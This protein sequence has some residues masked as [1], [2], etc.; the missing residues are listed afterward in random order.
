M[1]FPVCPIFISIPWE[2]HY[3]DCR[4]LSRPVDHSDRH[5]FP[6]T[7]YPGISIP[8]RRCTGSCR[9]SSVK[10]RGGHHSCWFLLLQIELFLDGLLLG[11]LLDPSCR[12]CLAC[13]ILCQAVIVFLFIR[14]ILVIAII[15]RNFFIIIQ[16][17]IIQRRFLPIQNNELS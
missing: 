10:V 11:L 12:R 16:R 1:D 5:A 14:T 13:F 8:L 7:T 2:G 6:R 15:I 9:A 3:F 4:Y 17:L